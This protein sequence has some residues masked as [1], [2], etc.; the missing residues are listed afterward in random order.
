MT[1]RAHQH[2]VRSG[3]FSY[4]RF[5][6]LIDGTV[7]RKA[8]EFGM[9]LRPAL[10]YSG[11]FTTDI[12]PEANLHERPTKSRARSDLFPLQTGRR[13]LSRRDRPAEFD[14]FASSG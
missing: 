4:R 1:Q 2:L 11:D 9:S 5:V 10:G 3:E 7:I 13:C 6:E 8:A 14:G 12:L